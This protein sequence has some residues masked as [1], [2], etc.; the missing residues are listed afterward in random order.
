MADIHLV[1]K[2]TVIKELIVDLK[3]GWH[4]WNSIHRHRQQNVCSNFYIWFC[5][6]C[7]SD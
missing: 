6:L 7:F 1:S 3:F 2:L 4:E 5:H